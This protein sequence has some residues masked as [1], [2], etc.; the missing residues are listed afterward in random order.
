MDASMLFYKPVAADYPRLLEL[1][2]SSVRDTHTF[3]EE[4]DIQFL[5]TLISDKQLFDMVELTCIKVDNGVIAGFMGVSADNLEMLFIDPEFRNMGIGK[6][7]LLHAIETV[8]VKRVDVNEQNPQ[9]VGFY[10][11]FGFKAVSRSEM[12]GMGL[13]FPILHMELA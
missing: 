10:E 8:G 11:R 6:T 5:K 2:E 1:W 9:A 13:P 7:L 3:L 12:D 4:K